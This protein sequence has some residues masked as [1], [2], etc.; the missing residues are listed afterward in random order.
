MTSPSHGILG[1]FVRLLMAQSLRDGL[2]TALMVFLAR[3]SASSFGEFV[4]AFSLAQFILFLGEF[5]LNQPMVLSLSR[6]Y[7]NKGEV[8]LQYGI[9]KAGLLGL[10]MVGVLVF[11]WTQHYSGSLFWMT[12]GICAGCGL[13]PLAGSFFV[14]CRVRGR[15]DAEA[16]IRGTGALCGY[17]F[18]L[19][20]LFFGWPGWCFGLFKVVENSVNLGA[21]AWFTMGWKEMTGFTLGRRGLERAWRTGQNGVVFVFMALAAIGYNKANVFFLQRHGGSVSVASYGVA[22]E[23]VDGVSN[24]VATLLLSGVIY[25]LLVKLWRTS[26]DEFALLARQTARSL[27]AAALPLM[28]VLIMETDRLLP[29]VYGEHYRA[30][31]W[32]AAWLAPSVLIAFVH[33]L[34]AYMMLAFGRER[35]LLL[36]YAC[37]LG[38]SVGLCAWLIPI[39]PLKGAA[40][41]IV[42][43]KAAVAACTV[44]Y[45]QRRIGLLSLPS[46][47]LAVLAA[48]M[49]VALW[50]GVGRVAPREA[51]EVLALLPLLGL[52]WRWRP[53]KA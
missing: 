35:L 30:D 9:I 24:M 44:G 23:L 14:A 6:K 49:S 48:G 29:L 17:G 15:Q 28:A 52:L 3:R 33:N 25:P 47:L 40:L 4:L 51:A 31:A 21:S 5:G 20:A 32:L 22:W 19:A 36:I 45:C 16:V 27:T 46:V 38:A 12:V 18:A 26:R 50:W 39:M 8:L 41:C 7:G 53:R 11:A 34:A 43:T 10:G 2:H 1:K 42:L 37:G 13:E